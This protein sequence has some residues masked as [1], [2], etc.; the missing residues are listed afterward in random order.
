MFSI[1]VLICVCWCL[2]LQ[3][4]SLRNCSQCL[5]HLLLWE[6]AEYQKE[7][8]SRTVC[9]LTYHKPTYSALKSPCI[10][11]SRECAG[12]TLIPAQLIIGCVTS[13]KLPSLSLSTLICQTKV[14]SFHGDTVRKALSGV[15]PGPPERSCSRLPQNQPF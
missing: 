6:E 10:G 4:V 15:L 2:Q 12:Q 14:T 3:S 13:G 1:S 8:N 7:E 5:H 11:D 9:G